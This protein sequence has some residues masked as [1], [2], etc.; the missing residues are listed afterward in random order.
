MTRRFALA[1]RLA[2]ILSAVILSTVVLLTGARDAHAQIFPPNM[3]GGSDGISVYGTGELSARPNMVEI[4]LRVAGKAELTGDALVKYRDAKKRVLEAL[5]KLKLKGLSSEE[6]A[7]TIAA[8]SN[9]EQQQRMMNG[10]PQVPVKTQIEVSSLL[11]VRLKEVRE[12]APEE[13]IKTV[14]KLLDVAQDS[15]VTL[16]LT[17]NEMM[18]NMRLGYN[19]NMNNGAPVR[20]VVADLTEVREKAYEQ[21]V[22]DARSRATRLAKLNQVKLGS[23]L[24]VQEVLV[25]GDQ[26]GNGNHNG[27][28]AQPNAGDDDD[29]PR[30]ASTTLS[31]IPVQVKLLVRFAIQP[32]DPATAQQ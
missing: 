26:L 25:A 14:G 32:P 20:F 24:S 9:A 29:E 15:G 6:L 7:L 1:S 13:L 12:L 11:R 28:S 30:I 4:D 8:G 3:G 5:E 10:M 27:Q 31:A 19:N 18:Y 21:A 2:V 22:A 23:A 16:G 17:Q